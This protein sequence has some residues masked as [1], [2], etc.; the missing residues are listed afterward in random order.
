[1]VG[2]SL[3]MVT[4]GL[5]SVAVA[6]PMFGDRQLGDGDVRRD[7]QHGPAGVGVATVTV[8]VSRASFPAA[9]RATQVTVVVPTAK[10]W[11]ESWLHGTPIAPETTSVAMAANVTIAVPVA[12]CGAVIGPGNVSTGGVVSRT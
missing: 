7:H 5:G 2:W 10:R 6:V 4:G 1:M 8:K 9:S 12:S 3:V 11:P